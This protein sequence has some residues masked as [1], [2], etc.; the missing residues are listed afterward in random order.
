[1]CFPDHRFLEEDVVQL[2]GFEPRRGEGR[3]RTCL[4]LAGVERERGLRESETRAGAARTRP[5]DDSIG[6]IRR[7]PH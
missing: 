4:S 6:E 5:A 3:S 1:M 7:V 2:L